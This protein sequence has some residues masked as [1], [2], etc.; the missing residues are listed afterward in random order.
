V[1]SDWHCVLWRQNF[2]L[3]K[4]KTIITVYVSWLL[5]TADTWDDEGRWDESNGPMSVWGVYLT[6]VVYSNYCSKIYINFVWSIFFYI[7]GHKKY[8]YLR[9][10]WPYFSFGSASVKSNWYI[11]SS[12][13]RE[14]VSWPKPHV[15]GT[16]FAWS[17][18]HSSI[19]YL[20]YHMPI[21]PFL[22]STSFFFFNL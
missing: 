12:P 19:I 5:I 11:I 13:T 16:P 20:I 14:S 15:R 1:K 3:Y 18:T 21:A 22:D 2:Y 10:D 17:L 8:I 9:C 6:Q 7:L 4:G